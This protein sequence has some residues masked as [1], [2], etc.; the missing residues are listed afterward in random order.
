[1]IFDGQNTNRETWFSHEKLKSSPWNDLSSTTPY[2]FSLRGFR[3]WN[4]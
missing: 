1:M 2:I 4:W 3:I